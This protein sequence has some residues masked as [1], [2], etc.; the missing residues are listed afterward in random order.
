MIFVSLPIIEMVDTFAIVLRGRLNEVYSCTVVR[1]CFFLCIIF[2]YC[3]KLLHPSYTL[4][5][6]H[7][8]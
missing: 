7:I 5:I 8:Q 1:I 2:I 3:M 4:H 6:T